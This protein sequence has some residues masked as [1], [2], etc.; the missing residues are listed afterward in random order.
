MKV[1]NASSRSGRNL[2]LPVWLGFAL[3]MFALYVALVV[4]TGSGDRGLVWIV[5]FV[6]VGWPTLAVGAVAAVI[7]TRTGHE[8][9]AASFRAVV[10]WSLLAWG[11]AAMTL[12]LGTTT[13]Y[14]PAAILWIAVPTLLGAASAF[15]V[16]A[17]GALPR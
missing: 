8:G 6:I 12:E 7:R 17:M 2:A 14:V 15:A 5:G 11:A 4:L 16:R 10:G 13:D 3:A 9:T 1:G